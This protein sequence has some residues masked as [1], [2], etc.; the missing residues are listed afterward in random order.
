[1]ARG[2]TAELRATTGA[3][4][5]EAGVPGPMYLAHF[6]LREPPFALTPDPRFLYLSDRHREGFAHLLYGLVEG[7]GFVQLT[8]EVGTGKTTLCRAL[9]EQLPEDVDCA[10]LLNPRVTPSELLASL[11]DEFGV[12]RPAQT[13]SQKV[14]VDALYAHLLSA[15]GRGRR[16]VAIIDEAQNLSPEVLEQLRLLTNLETTR[17]KLLQIILIGQPELVTIL[18]GP[19]LRQLRQRVTARYHLEPF[20][21]AETRAYIGHRMAVAG[22]ADRVFGRRACAAVH[23]R[24]GGVPRLINIYCDRALLGSY[25][26]G[27]RQIATGTVRKAIMEVEGRRHY[28]WSRWSA[29][30]GAMLL[31]GAGMAAALAWLGLW[32]FGLPER[33]QAQPETVEGRT[34]ASAGSRPDGAPATAPR[35]DLGAWLAA[36]RG[37]GRKA[38]LRALLG[39]WGVPLRADDASTSCG[40]VAHYGLQCLHRRG[41]WPELRALDLPAILELRTPA[42]ETRYVTVAALRGSGATLVLDGEHRSYPV[43]AI[44]PLWSGRST[45]LWRP[46]V[47]AGRVLYPGHSGA[48][49]LWL[50]EQLGQLGVQV[51]QAERPERFDQGLRAQV[52][53]F[54][55]S[56]ALRPDGVIG[57]ETL[58]HLSTALPG[59]PTLLSRDS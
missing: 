44:D 56:R 19:E 55:R 10:F 8:G 6:G 39:L 46:P 52:I 15:H 25:V 45:L 53:E 7:G 51:L 22:A 37:T 49:T 5:V 50:R 2:L 30:A 12:A 38:A 47:L 28:R 40:Q 57:P 18:A 32:P 33:L 20:S 27:R 14:L 23:R 13:S 42:A 58:L 24:A 43:D 9:L 48:E 36:A 29:V 17:K 54:Q 1:M 16:P 11:C 59:T 31:A 21:A 35:P 34:G 4:P 41:R 26:Q 3:A